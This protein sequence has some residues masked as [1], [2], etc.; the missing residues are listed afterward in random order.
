MKK[1]VHIINPYGTL[2]DEGWRKYRTNI[3]AE[4]F[5]KYGY[6]VTYWISNIDHRSKKKRSEKDAVKIVNEDFRFRIV[7]SSQYSSN[8][9]LSRIRYERSF[10]KKV[11]ELFLKN[12]LQ[13]DI[14]VITDP[15]LF[16]GFSVYKIAQ[17]TKSKFFIDILDLWPEV[18]VT[19]FPKKIRKLA[20]F[21]LLPLYYL[22]NQ[23]YKKADGFLAVTND[24]LEVAKKCCPN[25]SGRVVYIGFDENDIQN[26]KEFLALKK[27]EGET[28]VI[29]A[30]TLGINY[31]IKGVLEFSKILEKSN[32][33]AKLFIAG[34]GPEKNRVEA[35][36][37][38][39]SP[40]KTVFL[41]RLNA[42]EIGFL[43]SQCDV[44]LSTYLESSTV[45]MPVKAFDY[46]AFGLPV[47]NSL[48]REYG[49]LIKTE[50]IGVQYKA[51]DAKNLFQK[52]HLLVTNEKLLND[53]KKNLKRLQ[54]KFNIKN[55]YDKYI[56]FIQNQ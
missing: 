26:K 19:L 17:S 35:Y 34:D 54:Q 20:N 11:R 27:E 1:K 43:Y 9:S 6:D 41:G 32:L 29:Y 16:Y 30:G 10:G 4:Y 44:A 56:D 46:I 8:G 49:N 52:F 36:M 12:N 28:W 40:L 24:Y 13:S 50:K 42:D 18:F 2:P 23:L 47:I 15:A 51:E 39:F 7:V 5:V 53:C 38:N 25:T 55:Q 21:I 14:V 33:N 3:V 45:S 37:R 22:R 31:D 48:G